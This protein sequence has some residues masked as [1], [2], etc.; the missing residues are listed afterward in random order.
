MV[1][2]FKKLLRLYSQTP[3]TILKYPDGKRYYKE[4]HNIR[5]SYIDLNAV[6]VINRLQNFSHKAYIVGG[7][8]RDMLL[9]RKPKDFDVVTSA[10]PNE[11]QKVFTNSRVIGRRFKINHIIFGR[12]RI[13]EVST[14]RSIPTNRTETNKENLYLNK[15]NDFGTFKEDAAR[16]DLT[17]NAIFF[18]IR[19]EAIIDYTGGVEDTKN[20]VIRI[21]GDVNI[22]LPED[23][24]RMLRA[25]KFSSL[26]SFEIDQN[27]LKGIRKYRK[28]IRKASLARLHEEFNKIFWTGN[29]L[30]I[31]SKLAEFGLFKALFPKISRFLDS[32]HPGWD[33]FF[34]Q[35][36]IGQRLLIADKMISEYEDINTTIYYAI[37][38]ADLIFSKFPKTSLNR[39]SEK[40]IYDHIQSLSKET[41]FTKKEVER[42]TKI[43][44]SQNDFIL[45]ADDPKEQKK[46]KSQDY[47]LESFTFYKVNARANKDEEAIQKTFSWEID[48]KKKLF[49]AIHK[50]VIRTIHDQHDIT[51][52]ADPD[53]QKEPKKPQG[54]RSDRRRR[55][56]RT[57]RRP[58]RRN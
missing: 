45:Q 34:P 51:L 36:L 16:R 11:V 26:L 2:F 5:K 40:K 22:S 30:Q 56:S 41:G 46:L 12:N 38:I 19:N 50:K 39:E 29:S 8:V 14:A 1:Y 42:L 44:T 3:E 13:I 47:F 10:R 33:R 15:D 49:N 57:R 32:Q 37:L 54:S 23:P 35:T 9:N 18:D 28:M 4:F 52:Q 58:S 55:R 48:L 27:L 7:A 25:L 17:I 31:F 20:K 24:V 6:K 43:F 53:D 21:I